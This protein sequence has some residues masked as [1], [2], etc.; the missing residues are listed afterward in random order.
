MT[1]RVATYLA[2]NTFGT[3][4]QL[5]AA[6]QGRDVD[7]ELVTESPATS[8]DAVRGSPDVDVFW[9]CGGLVTELDSRDALDHE[10]VSAPVFR[11]QST[12][13]YHSVIVSRTD[14][15]STLDEALG[16]TVAINEWASWSGHRALRRHASPRW[17]AAE[18]LSG[19][20]RESLATVADGTAA[21]AAIDHSVWAATVSDPA[22]RV[23]DR[24]CDWPSP[25]VLVRRQLDADVK[26]VVV[27][28]LAEA[29]PD[30]TV[31]GFVPASLKQY[32]VM[33]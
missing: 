32:E 21:C 25:P 7:A 22:L 17:F 16:S 2:D 23:I 24:T 26:H 8:A 27:D 1:L 14:G 6:L 19:S 13:T 20:H 31:E 30:E 29:A 9:M 4:R 12:P 5:V 33:R 15:P 18:V 28:V 10:V 11:G 3:T